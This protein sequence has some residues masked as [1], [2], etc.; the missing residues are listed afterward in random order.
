MKSRFTHLFILLL[1]VGVFSCQDQQSAP[2]PSM[3]TS[4]IVSFDE[5]RHVATS[6]QIG[7]SITTSNV[8]SPNGKTRLQYR[9]VVQEYLLSKAQTDEPELYVFNYTKG[10]VVISGDKR[11]MPILAFSDKKAFDGNPSNLGVQ[12]WVSSTKNVIKTA[13]KENI[14]QSKEAKLAWDKFETSPANSPTGPTA[15]SGPQVIGGCGNP[16][17]PL[18][19]STW[20]QGAGYNYYCPAA[21]DGPCGKALTGCVAT[22]MAQVARFWHQSNQEQFA[23]SSMEDAIGNTCTPTPNELASAWLL[24]R[25]GAYVGMNYGGIASSAYTSDIRWGFQ[26]L[27]G[28]NSPG[29]YTTNWIT[30]TLFDNLN[31]GRPFI[32]RGEGTGGH[33]WVVDGYV[34]CSWNLGPGLGGAWWQYYHMNWGW[35]GY[36]DGWYYYTSI[37]PIH[38]NPNDGTSSEIGSDFGNNRAVLIN[39]HP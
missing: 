2:N 13:R 37:R 31:N 1:L 6:L 24:R 10:F 12:D 39:I 38:T 27:L 7:D 23:F 36:C 4:L 35:G 34:S 17:G 25:C 3:S 33:A 15:P 19:T 5:A 28:Y 21:N 14:K 29:T 20:D 22:A 8:V 18:L 9:K 32:M 26:Y 30:S 11:L 16:V